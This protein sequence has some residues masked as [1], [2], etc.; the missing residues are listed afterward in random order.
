MLFLKIAVNVAGLKWTLSNVL[1]PV[2]T[3]LSM[4][5]RCTINFFQVSLVWK[6]FPV[7]L[8]Q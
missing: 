3:E 2:S 7:L 8:S 4:L 1:V 5:F 6:L